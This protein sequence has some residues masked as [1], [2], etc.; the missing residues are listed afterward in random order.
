MP[1]TLTSQDQLTLLEQVNDQLDKYDQR[2][3][4]NR[5]FA[6]GIRVTTAALGA[7]VAVLL[8]WKVNDASLEWMKNLALVC[9]ALISIMNSIDTFFSFSSRWTHYK[10]ICTQLHFLKKEIKKS[11]PLD[12]TAASNYE[13]RLDE[14]IAEARRG[15]MDFHSK[16]K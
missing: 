9:G 16:R 8:G 4:V 5:A 11:S 3:D 10:G 14:L 13:S 2:K 15:E 6:V 12:L 7:A 1:A